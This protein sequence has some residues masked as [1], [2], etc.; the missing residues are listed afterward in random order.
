MRLAAIFSDHM[1]MQRDKD[2]YIFGESEKDER[3]TVSID[4]IS[5]SKD[6]KAG[7]WSFKIPA[8]EAGRVEVKQ[9]LIRKGS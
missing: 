6:V 2:N 3:I 7:S 4:D 1:V 8:H 9:N 5:V